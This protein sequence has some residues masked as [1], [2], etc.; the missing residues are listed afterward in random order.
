MNDV[1]IRDL[2]TSDPTFCTET[3][4]NSD[5]AQSMVTGRFRHLPS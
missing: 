5:A 1:R 4:T 3:T 2:M